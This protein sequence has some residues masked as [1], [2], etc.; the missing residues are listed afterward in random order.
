MRQRYSGDSFDLVKR[1][2]AD[3]LRDIAPLN[4]HPDFIPLTESIR[5]GEKSKLIDFRKAYTR[6]TRIPILPVEDGR[7]L[8]S[9]IA[10]TGPYST[11]SILLDPTTGIP[12]RPRVAEGHEYCSVDRIVEI[13]RKFRPFCLI[14]FDQCHD[15]NPQGGQSSEL[16]AQL[17]D[18]LIYLESR[19]LHAFFYRSHARFFFIFPDLDKLE[20]VRGRLAARGLPDS[21]MVSLSMP[22]G[23]WTQPPEPS[24][25]IRLRE[26]A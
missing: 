20:K 22:H 18:K 1:F 17:K 4:A 23:Y 11:F 7:G 13:N 6:V 25:E 26:E 14:C 24:E 12:T 9:G 3:T 5:V 19:E 15:R 16:K 21:R 10:K 2:F 8:S